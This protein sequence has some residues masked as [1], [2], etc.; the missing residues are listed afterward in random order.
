M[1]ESSS[2]VPV[3]VK[4]VPLYTEQSKAYKDRNFW[5][6]NYENGSDHLASYQTLN[7]SSYNLLLTYMVSLVVW[8][9]AS[10]LLI[11]TVAMHWYTPPWDVCISLKVNLIVD[12][13]PTVSCW[14]TTTSPAFLGSLHSSVG[15][16][17]WYSSTVALQCR[18]SRSP[19]V[20]TGIAEMVTVGAWRA[21]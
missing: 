13:F 7:T 1:F 15:V 8:L 3:K 17:V 4:T 11:F 19:A 12:A 2:T 6:W 20:T 10:K 16:T 21:G 18:A 9:R 14:P 5:R